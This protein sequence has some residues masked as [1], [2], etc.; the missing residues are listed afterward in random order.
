MRPGRQDWVDKAGPMR[1]GRQGWD[2]EARSPRLALATTHHLAEP[3]AVCPT[4]FAASA[5]PGF[6]GDLTSYSAIL[7][8]QENEPR[9]ARPGSRHR[10]DVAAKADT[11][12]AATA[13]VATAMAVTAKAATAKAATAMAVPEKDLEQMKVNVREELKHREEA[14][15]RNR[16]EECQCNVPP[17][18]KN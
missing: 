14:G 5:C 15:E 17:D 6:A 7:P 2:G 10:D 9:M 12:M 1:R 18:W 3:S 8:G 13:M 4:R 11:A 16:L